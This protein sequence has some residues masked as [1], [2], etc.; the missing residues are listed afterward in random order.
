[1]FQK[2][3]TES[4]AQFT[5][6]IT[7]LE[8]LHLVLLDVDPLPLP[9]VSSVCFG[10]VAELAFPAAVSARPDHASILLP[11]LLFHQT[12]VFLLL[13][14]QDVLVEAP[15]PPASWLRSEG[16]TG[17]SNRTLRATQKLVPQTLHLPKTSFESCRIP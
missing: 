11:H 9:A 4:E 16:D 14:L 3:T 7:A 2:L 1:M 17:R 5:A 8:L 6:T 15:E 12:D 10:L 13:L